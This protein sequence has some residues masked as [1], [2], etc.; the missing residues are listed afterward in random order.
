[1]RTHRLLCALETAN[2][3]EWQ[4]GQV[5]ERGLDGRVDETDCPRQQAE[6]EEEERRAAGP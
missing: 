3:R 2:E 5:Q 4:D 6:M 1:M